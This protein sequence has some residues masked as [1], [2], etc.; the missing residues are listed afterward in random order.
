MSRFQASGNPGSVFSQT[1]VQFAPDPSVRLEVSPRTAPNESCEDRV[2]TTVA[3]S[4]A[5]A[6]PVT[7]SQYSNTRIQSYRDAL[8]QQRKS[9]GG[10]FFQEYLF[11]LV[12]THELLAIFLQHRLHPITLTQ[13]ILVL[14]AISS[15]SL[16]YA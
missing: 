12:N 4:P 16:A 11:H 1:V 7:P 15:I 10:P 14:F 9:W 13:R 6:E 2:S 5:D 3:T 8:R